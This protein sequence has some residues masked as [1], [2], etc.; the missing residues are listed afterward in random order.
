VDDAVHGGAGADAE[1][2]G[3]DG[4]RSKGRALAKVSQAEAEVTAQVVEELYIAS[5]D[6][7]YDGWGARKLAGADRSQK[8]EN[9]K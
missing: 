1:G 5:G 2:E 7:Q 6:V 3:S 4:E 9:G 8:G